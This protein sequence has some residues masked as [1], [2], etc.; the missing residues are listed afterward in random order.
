MHSKN[1]LFSNDAAHSRWSTRSRS[2]NAHSAPSSRVCWK[3]EFLDKNGKVLPEVLDCSNNTEDLN[4]DF[5]CLK[6]PVKA[7]SARLIICR[8]HNR[9][10]HGVTDFT[11][12]APPGGEVK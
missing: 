10:R 7:Y 4:I 5:C 3:V 6:N 8:S 1:G 9:Y 12:F 2:A 11:L